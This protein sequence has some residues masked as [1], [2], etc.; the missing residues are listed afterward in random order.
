MD[1]QAVEFLIEVLG[2]LGQ[3]NHPKGRENPDKIMTMPIKIRSE[4]LSKGWHLL[5][6]N[7]EEYSKQVRESNEARRQETERVLTKLTES[8]KQ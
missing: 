7:K 3:M 1:N 4:L 5:E 2:A 6:G 8:K